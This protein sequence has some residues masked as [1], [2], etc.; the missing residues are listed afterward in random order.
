[1]DNKTFQ[2]S[3]NFRLLNNVPIEVKKIN[4]ALRSV[5][6]VARRVR[7]STSRSL[8]QIATAGVGAAAAVRANNLGSI[9]I[10]GGIRGIPAGD[11]AIGAT[12]LGGIRN[13]KVLAEQMRNLRDTAIRTGEQVNRATANTISRSQRIFSG[14]TGRM[15]GMKERVGGMMASMTMGMRTFGIAVAGALAIGL[16]VR[17]A[18]RFQF[19]FKDIRKSVSGTEEELLA[20][21]EQMKK[22]GAVG[23]EELAKVYT[24]VGK[25]GIEAP[26]VHDVGSSIIKISKALDISGESAVESVGRILVATNNMKRAGEATADIGDLLT[27]LENKLPNVAVGKMFDIWGYIAQEYKTAGMSMEQSAGM[28]SFIAQNFKMASSGAE[29]FRMMINRFLES[30]I[31]ENF[32]FIDIIRKR[33]TKGWVDV[34]S[35]ISEMTESER[36]EVFGSGAMKFI[37]KMM[38]PEAIKMFLAGTTESTLKNARGAVNKEWGVYTSTFTAKYE[39]FTNRI[40]NMMDSIG[41]PMRD[42]LSGA[43]DWINPKLEKMGEWL[44]WII[45]KKK[46]IN[47]YGKEELVIDRE[48]Q[49]KRM[50]GSTWLTGLI[51]LW[52]VGTSGL[53]TIVD[54]VGLIISAFKRL[55]PLFNAFKPIVDGLKDAFVGLKDA[56]VALWKY[57][58]PLEKLSRVAGK[59]VDVL[60]WTVRGGG[61]PTRMTRERLQALRAKD[62]RMS[63]ARDFESETGIK[64]VFFGGLSLAEIKKMN[65]ERNVNVKNQNEVAVTVKAEKGTEVTDIKKRNIPTVTF[66]TEMNDVALAGG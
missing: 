40:A 11:L 37:S 20:L 41:G 61:D 64:T 8:K 28:T 59:A 1:M 57:V 53:R 36:I 56:L 16:P 50:K 19:A 32:G 23:F 48:L 30:D 12:A 58:E 44:D 54:I 29:A 33:G 65:A 47:E 22:F 35:R 10:R 25:M 26:K 24:A 13:P 31:N 46:Q 9:P 42:M 15:R 21:R 43:L 60:E 14:F 66:G 34:M 38:D 63:E 6:K 51:T 52:N 55:Q 2:Y 27:H 62:E 3:L 4:D 18:A 5:S 49:A 45:P 39:E 17:Y 7:R